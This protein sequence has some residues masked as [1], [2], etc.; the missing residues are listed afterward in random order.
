MEMRVRR[1]R[2]EERFYITVCEKQGDKNAYEEGLVGG[3][4]K[5][6]KE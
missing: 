1:R 4:S 3:T 5:T 6:E 2:E